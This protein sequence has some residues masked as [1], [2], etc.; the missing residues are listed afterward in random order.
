MGSLCFIRQ[1]IQESTTRRL[2]SWYPQTGTQP[3]AACIDIGNLPL[4]AI[5]LAAVF[6]QQPI[7]LQP[8]KDLFQD[9]IAS[10]QSEDS[11]ADFHYSPPQSNYFPFFLPFG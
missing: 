10:I 8:S 2:C 7:Y 1:R 3:F 5:N 9:D 4:S 6:K 11:D